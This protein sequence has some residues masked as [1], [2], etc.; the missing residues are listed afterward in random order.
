MRECISVHVGQAGVQIGNACWELYCLEHGI[1]PDGQM[2]SDKTI[3]GGDDSFNTFFSETGAGKHVPRAVFIDLEPT[4]VDEVRT[5][6]YRQLFHPEQL[7]TGKEDAANNYARGHY[8]IGK[9]IVDLVLDRV[10]KLADQCTGLQG[11]LLFHSFGGG[12]GSGF[13]SLLMERLSVDYGKKSKLEFAVY[14]APQ[15][16][17]A[18]VEPYNSILTTHTTL[19]HSDCAFMVDNEAIYDICRRNLDIER[20]TYTNLNRLIGQIVSSITA[21]LRFDGA[22]NVDL[23]EFQ[24]NL[25]PYPRIHFPLATYAPVISAEKAYHEQLTVAEITNACFEPANQMVKCDPRHGKYMACCM[26]Y[27]GDVVPKDVNAAIATIKTK[28]TIQFVDWCPTGFKVGINYQPPTVVPGGDLAK[29]QR[30]VC[31]L[32]NTTAIAEAWA[33]LDHKFDLMYA[34]RAFVHWYVGEGMEEGEFAEA[35][36]DL[37]ALEKDYEEESIFLHIG[38]AGV[39]VGSQFWDIF[40]KEEGFNEAGQR[41]DGEMSISRRFFNETSTGTYVPRALFVD[42]CSQTIEAV[43]SRGKIP[44]S[45]LICGREGSGGNYARSYLTLSPKLKER[46]SEG[47][48]KLA[49][50]CSSL[51]GFLISHSFGGG[52]GAGLTASVV[53][54]LNFDYGQRSLLDFPV[55]PALQTSPLLVEPFNG[56][57]M[58]DAIIDNTSCS[59]VLD[60]VALRDISS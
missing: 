47:I 49:E 38:G 24:T 30:A 39:Q 3:G 55:Y 42:L 57:L 5:G 31:M 12:T 16:S 21:S 46:L 23:T 8:T 1:Q 36:E 53:Q 27:R 17:T 33:R 48:R 32:S 54:H 58:T 7:I 59:F 40:S 44:A 20:P 25:V 29:V 43:A 14:P 15:I 9:E 34:K 10:R 52:T 37:A 2:P 51:E 19:E 22:L 60:N 45:Q 28:R 4:V 6:T 26:L 35:R 50:P 56:I 13:T 41:V 11:F 18:V